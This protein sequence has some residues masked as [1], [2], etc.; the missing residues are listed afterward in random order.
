MKRIFS[1]LIIAVL[2]GLCLPLNAQMAD[3]QQQAGNFALL[4]NGQLE[5]GYAHGYTNTPYY[6]EE[7]AT[8]ALDFRGMHYEDVALRLDCYTQRLVLRSP[9]GRFHLSLHPA[10]I[11]RAVV[12]GRTFAYFDKKSDHAPE[13][14]YYVVL[15]E[16]D[17]WGLY[18]L[19]YVNNINKEYVEHHQLK[20]F[21]TSTRIYLR[22]EGKWSATSGQDDFVRHFKDCKQS[23]KKYCK[24]QHLKLNKENEDDWIRLARY[25]DTLTR[26]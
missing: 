4:Y 26:P 19:H 6:P 13:S 1:I 21:S 17:G 9:D 12:G 16:T 20:K 10:E 2:G 14:T 3:Y 22:K 5:A 23:L 15:Y 8:G 24:D 18:K 7:Y 11:E 25:C